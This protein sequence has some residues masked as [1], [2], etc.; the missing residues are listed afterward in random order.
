MDDDELQDL[1]DDR[2]YMIVKDRAH[3]R[4]GK[5][6]GQIRRIGECQSTMPGNRDLLC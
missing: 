3:A 5:I 1:V 4:T 6:R 2:L